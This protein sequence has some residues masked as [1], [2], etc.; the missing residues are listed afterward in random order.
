V[1]FQVTG[2]AIYQD[3]TDAADFNDEPEYNTHPLSALSKAA[4][5]HTIRLLCTAITLWVLAAIATNLAAQQVLPKRKLQPEALFRVRQVGAVAWS[6]DG[7]YAAIELTRPD[8]ALG[9]E[10]FNE[11]GLLDVKSHV[12]R[13]LS[14]N[15]PRYVGFFNPK[16]SPDGH[17]LASCFRGQSCGM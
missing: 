16:W 11:M 7:L 5:K 1:D 14:S 12:L 10:V 3:L 8:R 4:M 9:S 17:R 2:N 13:T 15:A 6:A